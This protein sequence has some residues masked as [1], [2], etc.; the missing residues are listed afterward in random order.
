MG[1][2]LLAGL[3]G[4]RRGRRTRAGRLLTSLLVLLGGLILRW[5]ILNAGKAGADDPALYFADTKDPMVR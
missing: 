1:L 5:G 2:P 4:L 3:N